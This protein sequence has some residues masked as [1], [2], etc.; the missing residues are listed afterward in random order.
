MNTDQSTTANL[1]VVARL[2][3]SHER[4]ETALWL[5]RVPV[6]KAQLRVMRATA[7]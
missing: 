3:D 6:I 2:H 5:A 4:V 7:S 1:S